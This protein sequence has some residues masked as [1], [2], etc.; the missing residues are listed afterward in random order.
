MFFSTCNFIFNQKYFYVE[1]Q[2]SEIRKT[3][4]AGIICEN[5]DAMDYIQPKVF[6]PSTTTNPLTSCSSPALP[7]LNLN[8]WDDE[9]EDSLFPLLIPDGE[10]VDDKNPLLTEQL[11]TT[12]VTTDLVKTGSNQSSSIAALTDGVSF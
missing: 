10:A 12:S 5:A 1:G 6:Q 8:L 2:L 9:E 4:L 7:R 11:D 3:S